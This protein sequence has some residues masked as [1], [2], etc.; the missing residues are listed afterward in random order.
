[1]DK[2]IT[3]ALLIFVSMVMVVMLFNVAYPAIVEGGDAITN[4]A[5]RTEERMQT[6]V[7]IIHA[8]SELDDSGWWQD[9]NGNGQFEVYL[10]IKNVGDSRITALETSDVFFGPEGNFARIPH[11]STAN[12]SYPRW[13][14]SLENASEWTPTATLRIAIHYGAP[15][16]QGRYFAKMIAPSGVWDDYFMGL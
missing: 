14:W 10:W 3:T 1:M 2:S 5:S 16:G 13:S 8:T 15:L 9:S 6:Q 12:G 7:A 11:E 4:M